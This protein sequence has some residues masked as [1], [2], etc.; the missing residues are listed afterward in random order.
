MLKITKCFRK[1]PAKVCT[2]GESSGAAYINKDV[3]V[4]RISMIKTWGFSN[5]TYRFKT[6]PA[7]LQQG[8]FFSLFFF[9]AVIKKAS[10]MYLERKAKESGSQNNFEKR[11][12]ENSQSPV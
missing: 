6:I 4:R 9:E 7:K 10:K 11:S 5:R 2:N 1:K 12:S 3:H 8:F